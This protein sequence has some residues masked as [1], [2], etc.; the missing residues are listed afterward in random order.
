MLGS[1]VGTCFL[2]AF[3]IKSNEKNYT[4]CFSSSPQFFTIRNT[5]TISLSEYVLGSQYR[6][7]PIRCTEK[8]QQAKVL[9]LKAIRNQSGLSRAQGADQ[10]NG[11]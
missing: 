9:T 10:C 5:Q 8:L 6:K 2:V 4:G 7:T 1:F 11:R 3:P